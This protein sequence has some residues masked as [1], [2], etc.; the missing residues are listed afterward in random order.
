[1]SSSLDA[2]LTSISNRLGE[3]TCRLTVVATIFLPLTFLTGFF[4]MNFAFLV[5]H[6]ATP[7]AFFTGLGVMAISVPS[8]VLVVT[9][10]NR[11]AAPLPTERRTRRVSMMSSRAR[12]AAATASQGAGSNLSD[13]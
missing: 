5:G 4:G 13:A 3:Q 10:L 7:L 1:M 11:R 12:A 6:I 8:L 2:Y 9:R